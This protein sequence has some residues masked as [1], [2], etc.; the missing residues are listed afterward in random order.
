MAKDIKD[1]SL[2]LN[3]VIELGQVDRWL[4]GIADIVPQ[5]TDHSD[6]VMQERELH[7]S[8]PGLTVSVLN[9]N[10]HILPFAETDL[11]EKSDITR[12][13]GFQQLIQSASRSNVRVDIDS[14]GG[15]ALEV[16]FE[17]DEPFSRSQVFGATYANVIPAV[18]GAKPGIRK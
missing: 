7:S 15:A 5:P 1:L 6:D 9:S 17:P 10:A 4:R 16:N 13:K 2:P 11:V 12:M 3:K 18:I 14:V 8:L